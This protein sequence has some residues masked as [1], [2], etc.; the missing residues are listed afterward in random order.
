VPLLRSTLVLALGLAVPAAAQAAAPP[1]AALE[2]LLGTA[3]R[4]LRGDSPRSL[5]EDRSVFEALESAGGLYRVRLQL[6]RAAAALAGCDA[7]VAGLRAR[8]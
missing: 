4:A 7:A 8:D 3:R 1:D 2:E 6:A 5:D